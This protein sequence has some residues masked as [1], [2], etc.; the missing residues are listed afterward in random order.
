MPKYRFSVI[1]KNGSVIDIYEPDC[2]SDEDAYNKADMLKGANVIDIWQGDRWVGMV[3]GQ[4][5]HRMAL[6]RPRFV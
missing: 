1:G 3:D 4:D 5:P 2:V 6:T